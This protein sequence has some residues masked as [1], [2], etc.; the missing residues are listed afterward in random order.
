MSILTLQHPTTNHAGHDRTFLL[1]V[2]VCEA[3]R[4]GRRKQGVAHL[5]GSCQP[6]IQEQGVP[7]ARLHCYQRGQAHRAEN[8]PVEGGR[9]SQTSGR[10]K[11]YVA[12]CCCMLLYVAVNA[13]CCCMLLYVAVETVCYCMLLYVAV[14][15][16]MVC[17]GVV[18]SLCTLKKV[19]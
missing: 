11:L 6:Q 12:V 19:M 18:C 1:Q 9:S 15:C 3:C 10:C 13:V 16:C 5:E 2:F 8:R 4:G 17:M 14:C 7:K